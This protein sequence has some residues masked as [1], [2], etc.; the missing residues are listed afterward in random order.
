SLGLRPRRDGA[1]FEHIPGLV[2]V[3]ARGRIVRYFFGVDYSARD[4]GRALE[5][6][7][8]GRLGAIVDAALLLCF[9]YDPRAAPHTAAVLGLLRGLAAASAAALAAF[10]VRSLRRERRA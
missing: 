1:A 9:R 7:G 6:A 2:V 10:V 4:L 8:E 5:R 3:T